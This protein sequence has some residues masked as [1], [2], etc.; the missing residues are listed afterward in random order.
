MGVWFDK[1]EIPRLI[2]CSATGNQRIKVADLIRREIGGG[3]NGQ[4][5]AYLFAAD[6]NLLK[7]AVK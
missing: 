2:L 4:C 7:A 3:P 5:A 6:T 1:R